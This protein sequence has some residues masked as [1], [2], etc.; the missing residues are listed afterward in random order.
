MIIY[1]TRYPTESDGLLVVYSGSAREASEA[2]KRL[3][4]AYGESGAYG[5]RRFVIHSKA[6]LLDFLRNHT[7]THQR[8]EQQP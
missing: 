5:T 7:Q 1:R 3:R 4:K 2:I 6:E 8:G